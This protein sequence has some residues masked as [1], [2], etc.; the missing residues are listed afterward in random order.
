MYCNG[1]RVVT[2]NTRGAAKIIPSLPHNFIL[3]WVAPQ[4]VVS[5]AQ[6]C[7]I[8]DSEWMLRVT[9]SVILALIALPLVG[10]SAAAST[11]QPWEWPIEAPHPIV[12]PYLAPETPY[13]PGH[14]G[15]DIA[16]GS[17]S[18]VRAPAAGVVHYSG[19][20]VD[21]P[22]LSIRH[23]GGVI[24]SYEPVTSALAPGDTV[25]GGQIVGELHAGHCVQRCLHFGVRL[26]GE[27]VSPLNYLAAIPRAILL[28]T[29]GH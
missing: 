20:V 24:S 16:A 10:A 13:S 9:V 26:D 4:L 12:R 5:R 1:A 29:R 23:D 25:V 19:R 17:T 28:P 11:I 22:V 6:R 15:I 14:R 2:A 3:D 21:R 27:Y 18:E 8:N 7:A